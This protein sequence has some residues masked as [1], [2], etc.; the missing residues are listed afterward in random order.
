MIRIAYSSGPVASFGI[1]AGCQAVICSLGVITDS[2]T[3]GRRGACTDGDVAIEIVAG[4]GTG[5]SAVA[6]GYTALADGLAAVADGY[7]ITGACQC[8]ITDGDGAG[9]I[10]RS[11]RAGCQGVTV[12]GSG[13][14][15][16]RN[17][18]FVAG[19]RICANSNGIFVAGYGIRADGRSI[20]C[21]RF[22][23]AAH[24]VGVIGDS[25]GVEADSCRFF[26]QGNRGRANGN[27]VAR[28]RRETVGLGDG[29]SAAVSEVT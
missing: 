28:I 8:P 1:E 26:A 16:N 23:H 9:A 2:D 18:M 7:G 20:Q 25:P 3:A 5:C 24:G 13:C 29:R 21:C 12:L 19:N 10:G 11:T 6:D 17:G 27:D 4:F 15:T 14:F 22:G